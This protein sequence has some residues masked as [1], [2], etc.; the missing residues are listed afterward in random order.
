MTVQLAG[1]LAERGDVPIGDRCAIDRSF[2]LIGNRTAILL[3]REAFYGVTRFDH[4]VKRVGVTE[5]VA[6]QRLRELVE[7]GV[8]TKEP[9]REPGQRTRYEYVLTESGHALMPIMLGFLEW[10]GTYHPYGTGRQTTAVH[11]GCG[12][13]VHAVMTCESGHVVPEEDLVIVGTRPA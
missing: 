11:A 8:L 13:E 2:Q 5:A 6:A 7:A 12:A 4:L 9:Y 1:G 3:L 10:G